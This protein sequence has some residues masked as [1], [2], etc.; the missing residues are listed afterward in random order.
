MHFDGS[1]EADLFTRTGHKNI[2]EAFGKY[3]NQP[4]ENLCTMEWQH[5]NADFGKVIR[6]GLTGLRQEIIEAR[7]HYHNDISRLNFL[8]A[9]EAMIR[10][11]TRRS[12]QYAAECRMQA[13]ICQDPA[14]K[15]VLLRM[16][17]NCRQVPEYPARTFEEKSAVPR[18]HGP[19][20]DGPAYGHPHGKS[21][22]P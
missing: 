2:G 1:V 15:A 5:S 17:S 10:G 3:Y 9:L 13:T 11:I 14:R 22:D 20:P 21:P 8:A 7:R 16:A 6:I 18:A 19:D 4:Q 12:R